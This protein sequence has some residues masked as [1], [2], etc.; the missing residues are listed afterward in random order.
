MFHLFIKKPWYD[1]I[2]FIGSPILA[3]FVIVAI[4]PARGPG[5]PYLFQTQ[6]PGWLTTFTAVLIFMHVMAGFT[7]SHLNQAVF[8]QHKVRFTWVPL[9]IFV[10]LAS[11][12]PLFVFVLPFVAVWDEIHQFMQTFGFGRIY[13]GKRGNNPLVGRK[14]DMAACFIIEYYPHI[15]R[16]MSIP[17]NEFKQEMEVFGEFAPDLY[18]YAPKLILPMIILGVA[19]LIYYIFWYAR[20]VREGY[21]ISW[22]KMLLYFNTGFA[23]LIIVKFYSIVD[24]LVLSNIF[25][26]TPP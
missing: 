23:T 25:G 10:V 3:L 21:E 18:L 8:E 11:Y 6:T 16:T 12:N 20:R 7:R 1:L 2:F 14:M 9:I 17:Y 5:D 13:D 22:Q 4:V 15:I 19:F 24:A 26:F